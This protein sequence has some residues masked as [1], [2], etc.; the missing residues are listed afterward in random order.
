MPRLLVLITHFCLFDCERRGRKRGELYSIWLR[1]RI[2]HGY[3]VVVHESFGHGG[4]ILFTTKLTMALR[5]L[6]LPVADLAPGFV[7]TITARRIA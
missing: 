3:A 1:R 2:D 7:P 4:K 5:L 6:Y